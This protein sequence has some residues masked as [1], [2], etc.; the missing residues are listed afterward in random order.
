VEELVRRSGVME[1]LEKKELII[2]I[3]K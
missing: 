1:G 3:N 2:K